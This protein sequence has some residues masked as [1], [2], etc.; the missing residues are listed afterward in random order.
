MKSEKTLVVLSANE[1]VTISTYATWRLQMTVIVTIFM[2]LFGLIPS[3]QAGTPGPGGQPAPIVAVGDVTE[4]DD[5]EMR[6]YVGQV[7][8]PSAVNLVARVSGELGSLGF[9]EGSI[10]QAGDVLFSIDQVRYI[11]SVKSA[12]AKIAEQKARVIYSDNENTRNQNL[13][14]NSVISQSTLESTKSDLEAQQAALDAAEAAL[15]TARDDLKN[16]T[17]VAPITGK[18]GAA[19]VTPGNYVTPSSGTLA[20]IVQVD[21]LRVIFAMSNRDFLARF[22]SE[23]QLKSRASIKLKLSD[24][25][26]YEF[27]GSVEFIDNQANRHTDSVLIYTSFPNPRGKLLPGSTVTVSLARRGDVR[28]AAVPASAVMHDNRGDYVYVVGDGNVVERRNVVLASSNTQNQTIRS[29]LTPGEQVI[30]DGMHKTRPGGKIVP[31]YEQPVL[32][33]D[34]GV[35]QDKVSIGG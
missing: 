2:L 15:V 14:T 33:A 25:S 8:S 11:A 4:Q 18:I 24:D 28:V 19:L 21:P 3:L 31:V 7:T 6:R 30:I 27:A 22:G 10:V 1:L 9:R 35:N 20:T 13:Y 34:H 17:I 26:E 29:G 12:E 16:T 23:E 32:A 5:I